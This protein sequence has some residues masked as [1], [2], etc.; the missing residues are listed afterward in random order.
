[1]SVETIDP[2]PTRWHA[3]NIRMHN[4]MSVP[5]PN[6][7]STP[8][9]PQ[10]RA[11][12]LPTCPLIALGVLDKEGRPW[13]T[14]W[15]GERGLVTSLGD[16]NIGTTALVDRKWDPVIELLGE[17]REQEDLFG[18]GSKIS[19]LAI[20]LENRRRLKVAGEVLGALF[21]QKE[22]TGGSEDLVGE[23]QLVFKVESS[24]SKCSI[25]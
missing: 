9:L 19:A 14:L 3:G 17:G 10:N 11:L 25:F 20:D 7:P 16:D 12:F 5:P 8:Y 24:L 15:G 6:N 23:V 1:M 13:T 2:D 21:S 18:R 22:Q 4:L